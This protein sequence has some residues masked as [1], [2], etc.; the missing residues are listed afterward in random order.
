MDDSAIMKI[1]KELIELVEAGVI[2]QSTADDISDYYKSRRGSS[3]SRL[4][5]IFGVLGAMLVG[6]GIILILA[7]NWDDLSRASK[8]V[9]AF[10]PLIA[11]QLICAYT[12]WKQ[13]ESTAWREGATTFLVFA[14]GASISL[15][16]QIYNIPGDL[17][18]FFLTWSLLCLPLI[19]VMKSSTASLLYLIGIT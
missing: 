3:K 18:S 2:S 7:H 8:T 9:I 11:G 4:L 5:I 10:I 12:L 15:V 19:Y 1:Q 6:L 13:S 14:V 17:G 16:S